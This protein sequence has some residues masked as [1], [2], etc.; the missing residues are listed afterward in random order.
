MNFK[1]LLLVLFIILFIGSEFS[2]A[3][4]RKFTYVYQSSVMGK[5]FKEIEISTTTRLGKNDGYYAAIDN[6]LEFEV[7][8]GG[9]LQTAFYINF[10]NV[11]ASNEAGVNQ[12]S[13]VFKGISSEW[14]YQVSDPSK[15]AVGFALY[16]ELGL[17]T[18][19]AELETKLIFD[20][21]INKTTLALNL[22]YEP[23]WYF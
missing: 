22:T 14:K 9:K 7:G 19:E 10:S 15:N 21:K 12:T 8:V 6:R 17:N 1:S 20:K 16:N 13:F 18:D 23:E 3:N 11:T 5:G 4:E 2:F